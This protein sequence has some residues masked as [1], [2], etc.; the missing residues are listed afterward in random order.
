MKEQSLHP[1]DE[2]TEGTGMN[3]FPG[4][5]FLIWWK[6]PLSVATMN[7]RAGLFPT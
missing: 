1:Q 7:F 4:L 3:S 5:A 2:S 6:M